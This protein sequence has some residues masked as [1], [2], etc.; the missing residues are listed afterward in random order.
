MLRPGKTKGSSI[1]KHPA[2]FC[3]A[4]IIKFSEGNN[5]IDK[6]LVGPN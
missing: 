2:Y 5:V 3:N 1:A 6:G 4:S